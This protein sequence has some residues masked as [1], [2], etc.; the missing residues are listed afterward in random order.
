MQLRN[1]NVY[2][3]FAVLI[4]V[5]V[6]A[7]FVV[8]PFLVPLLVAAILAH[9]FRP[10]F[11]FFLKYLRQR[12]FSSILT[13]LVIAL[14]IIAPV[15]LVLSLVAN[16]VQAIVDSLAGNPESIK[17][18]LSEFLGNVSE[19]PLLRNF[20]LENLAS[21]E[22]IISA[23]KSFSQNALA[24]L[25]GTYRGIAHFI[26]VTFIMFFSLFYLLLDGEKL[27]RKIMDLSP[28]Q[29]KYEGILIQKFNSITRATIKGTT[30]IAVVQGI[31]GSLLFLATGVASPIFFG[32]MMTV[33]SVIP[34]VGSG[35]IWFPVGLG[36][37][38]L[39][40]VTQGIT[41]FL[42]GALV[43]STVDNFLRP[44]LVGKDTQ[45]HPLLI[46][47]STL[48]GIA[49]FGIS[50]FIVGPIIMSLFVALWDIYALEF[51]GQLEEYNK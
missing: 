44:R 22:S 25:Q 28:L 29:D 20:E 3:F 5:T 2:F 16:E 19:F 43:I 11:Q 33:S 50:G 42:V 30:L 47:F 12:S 48:G 37:L 46:L 31:L 40:N 15:L 26:F 41:I 10:L 34:S 4:G 38:L 14:I 9:L 32:I 8:K 23:A 45:M 27:V 49:L 1:Y 18:S 24:I 21:Q 6:L 13:C 51:K 17:R 36:M 7:Y 35:L 39:G